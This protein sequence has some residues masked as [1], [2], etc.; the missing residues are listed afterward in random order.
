MALNYDDVRKFHQAAREMQ[1]GF[2]KAALEGLEQLLE[3]PGFRSTSKNV[4][5]EAQM[6]ILLDSANGLAKTNEL[7]DSLETWILERADAGKQNVS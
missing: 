6:K 4:R 3:E 7:M 5:W 2:A 1:I